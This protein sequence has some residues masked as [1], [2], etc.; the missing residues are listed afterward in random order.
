[1]WRKLFKLFIIIK[2]IIW[3]VLGVVY[4]SK[5]QSK[6]A[7]IRKIIKTHNEVN[8]TNQKFPIMSKPSS[9]SSTVFGGDSVRLIP[10]NWWFI[11]KDLV[12]RLFVRIFTY[13]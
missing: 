9:S 6:D 2:L 3:L 1:M 7:H 12:I 11:I 13:K 4:F 5:P 8:N 10:I